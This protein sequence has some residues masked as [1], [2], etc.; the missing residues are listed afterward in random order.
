[1]QEL[2]ILKLFDECRET[3][4]SQDTILQEF[5]YPCESQSRVSFKRLEN[6]KDLDFKVCEKLHYRK[7]QS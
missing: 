5:Y 7:K 2:T 4:E 1:M 3:R 6:K